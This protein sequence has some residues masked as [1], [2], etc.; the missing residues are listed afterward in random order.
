MSNFHKCWFFADILYILL[1]VDLIN[2]NPSLSV[3][4]NLQAYL[5]EK[6]A[7]IVQFLAN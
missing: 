2:S 1:Q 5:E 6:L 7:E 3:G 4:P